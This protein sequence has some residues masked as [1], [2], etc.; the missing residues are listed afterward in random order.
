MDPNETPH[1]RCAGPAGYALTVR[2]AEA[3]RES[4][5]VVDPAGRVFRL[6]FQETVTRAMCNVVGRVEW[7]MAGQEAA[8]LIV[9]V[10]AREELGEP[11]KVTRTLL[12]V[13]KITPEGAC[14]TRVLTEGKQTMEEAQRE[15]D[16]ARSQPCAPALPPLV[17]GGE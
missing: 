4:V 11:E 1:L 5:D 17:T 3:G 13:A 14:V 12:V 7:R 15:A 8:A 16:R 6:D 2:R 9:R 10:Q